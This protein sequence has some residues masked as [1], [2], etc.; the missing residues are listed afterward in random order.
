MKIKHVALVDSSVRGARLTRGITQPKLVV[1]NMIGKFDN[2]IAEG[3]EGSTFY[4]PIL[5]FPDAVPAA[6]RRRLA[7]A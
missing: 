3:V 1:A 7:A 5:K 6:E 4:Q 2:L